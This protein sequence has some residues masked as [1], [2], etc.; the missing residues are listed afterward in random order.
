MVLLV[1]KGAGDLPKA[2]RADV[3]VESTS[4]PAYSSFSMRICITDRACSDAKTCFV[5]LPGYA[6]YLNFLRKA[7]MDD[8]EDAVGVPS[9]R[10]LSWLVDMKSS[11][12]SMQV[13]LLSDMKRA[14]WG[15]QVFFILNAA[16]TTT[17]RANTASIKKNRWRNHE[18][19]LEM[20]ESLL[21]VGVKALNYRNLKIAISMLDQ[22]HL[23]LFSTLRSDQCIRWMAG[24]SPDPKLHKSIPE[25]L[26]KTS[27]R[28]AEALVEV[29][30]AG[31][32]SAARNVF[33]LDITTEWLVKYA[34][35]MADRAS[36]MLNKDKKHELGRCYYFSSLALCIGNNLSRSKEQ[37]RKAIKMEPNRKEY[38][39]HSANIHIWQAGGK[40]PV[41]TYQTVDGK[42]VQVSKETEDRDRKRLGLLRKW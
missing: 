14:L 35:V 10:E 24:P 22:A 18:Q 8:Y 7:E 36:K 41:L 5:I 26:Y 4:I 34:F 42:S 19:F 15:Y 27:I 13:K 16:D 20:I 37:I 9:F 33:G 3:Q 23:Q 31:Q 21:Y 25:L 28:L 40:I 29:A 6:S 1:L 39:T 32:I 12:T 38:H 30:N 2:L 11:S 17:A